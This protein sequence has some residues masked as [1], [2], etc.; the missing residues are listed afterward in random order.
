MSVVIGVRRQ[1]ILQPQFSSQCKNSASASSANYK[2]ASSSVTFFSRAPI[3]N[4]N[5]PTTPTKCHGQMFKGS[6]FTFNWMQGHHTHSKSNTLDLKRI[7]GGTINGNFYTAKGRNQLLEIVCIFHN[8]WL[9]VWG[10][11]AHNQVNQL[12]LVAYLISNDP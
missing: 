9:L 1:G 6:D 3:A 7:H 10:K 2:Q 11:I 8:N 4:C 5:V 12:H